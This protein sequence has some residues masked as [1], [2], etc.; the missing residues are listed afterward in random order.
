M[1]LLC[2]GTGTEKRPNTSVTYAA[3]AS[4]VW[5]LRSTDRRAHH[6]RRRSGRVTPM[7]REHCGQQRDTTI[8]SPPM[9][10]LTLVAERTPLRAYDLNGVVINIGRGDD[11]DVVIDNPSVSRRQAQVRLD[12]DGRWIVED[13]KSANGTSLNGHRLTGPA[14]L[15]RGDEISFGK[16]SIFFDRAL[17]E[18]VRDKDAAKPDLPRPTETF[19]MDLQELERLQKSSALKRR[20]HLKWEAASTGDTFYLERAERSAEDRSEEHTSE[21]QSR[22]NLVCR[23]LLEKKKK[24]RKTQQD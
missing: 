14:P 10:T 11:M 13:L 8:G 21:L 17:K 6:K 15:T 3:V 7:A 23:L 1:A 12:S 16:F 19:Q 5:S 24:R 9:P 4:L 22:E 18:P 20:A 2:P